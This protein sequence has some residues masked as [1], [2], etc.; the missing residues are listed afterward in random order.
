M[1]GY[2]LLLATLLETLNLG[3]G[4]DRLALLAWLGGAALGTPPLLLVPNL[5]AL[6]ELS[7]QVSK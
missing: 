2:R 6:T 4:L 7:K 5:V 1:L 3:G